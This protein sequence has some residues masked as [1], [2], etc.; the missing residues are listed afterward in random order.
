MQPF[1]D[2]NRSTYRLMARLGT[3][4]ERLPIEIEAKETCYAT[5]RLARRIDSGERPLLVF[6]L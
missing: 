4:I 1:D 2:L 3:R 6:V 5:R